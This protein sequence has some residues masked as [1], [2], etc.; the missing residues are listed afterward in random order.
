VYCAFREIGAACPCLG[1][2]PVLTLGLNL[3]SWRSPGP[4]APGQSSGDPCSAA[5]A[6]L[7]TS[8]KAPT[9]CMKSRSMSPWLGHVAGAALSRRR[10]AFVRSKPHAVS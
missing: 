10:P 3:G 7:I 1:R 5:S 9:R 2:A 6:T 4:G 8:S